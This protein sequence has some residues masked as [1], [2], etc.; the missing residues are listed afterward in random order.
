MVR[1]ET[2]VRLH[3]RGTGDES[4]IRQS[5]DRIANRN[6]KKKKKEKEIQ[7]L[8]RGTTSNYK[9]KKDIMHNFVGWGDVYI[10]PY[11]SSSYVTT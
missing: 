5:L 8:T 3:S 7:T 6:M 1:V 2:E 4:Q 10:S 9:I 11:R